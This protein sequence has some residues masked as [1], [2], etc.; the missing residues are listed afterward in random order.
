L[1][2]SEENKGFFFGF[3]WSIYMTSQ[4]IGNGIGG[5]IIVQTSGPWFFA[6]MG[7]IMLGAVFGFTF[8]I[9]PPH[10]EPELSSFK[11]DP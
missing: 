3:F 9:V 2:A 11:S 8:V 7:F 5:I 4:I 10:P 6:I 1:C